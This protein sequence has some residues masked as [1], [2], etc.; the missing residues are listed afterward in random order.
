MYIYASTLRMVQQ[1]IA[2]HAF[3]ILSDGSV[4]SGY[5]FGSIAP[6]VASL[7]SGKADTHTSYGEVVFNTSMT[8]YHEILTDPSYAGQTVVMTYPHIGNYGADPAWNENG[9]EPASRRAV[10][11]SGFVVRSIYDGPL[12]PGRVSLSEFMAE[13]KIPGISGVDTRRLTLQLRDRGSCNGTLVSSDRETLTAEEIEQVQEW[14]SRQPEMTGRNMIN[15]VGTVEKT[16]SGSSGNLRM[17][18]LDCGIKQNI[19]RELGKRGVDVRI[20]PAC[21]TAGEIAASETDALFL[22]NGPGDP[23]VLTHQIQLTRELIKKMPVFGICLGHQII[24][25][26]LEAKTYKMKFGHHGA[27]HPVRDEFTRKVCVTS[28]NH[29]FAVDGESLPED[30]SVWFTNANDNSIEGI[31]HDTLPIKSVQFH[32][33][34]A[35]GPHDAGWIFDDFVATA[36]NWKKSRTEGMQ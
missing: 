2:K 24:S 26:A 13:Q 15:A 29:G 23:A 4:F 16:S 27:N 1:M 33:E 32:P 34:A 10:K 17:A 21:T 11:A 20:Y 18:L 35:P 31:V 9:P 5:P 22:S 25:L 28:Q 8:G 3:L 12:P 36:V 19:I 30:V 7:C 6:A 14:L